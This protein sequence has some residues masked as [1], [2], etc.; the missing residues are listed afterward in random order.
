MTT[1]PSDIS[2]H[3]TGALDSDVAKL[4]QQFNAVVTTLRLLAAQVDTK[5]TT[6]LATS[7]F[8]STVSGAPCLVQTNVVG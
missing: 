6:T 4:V 7:L 1:Y 5:V 2:T 8:A 3:G